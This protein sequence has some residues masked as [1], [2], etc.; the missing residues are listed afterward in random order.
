MPVCG[1]ADFVKRLRRET[2]AGCFDQGTL[3]E[4]ALEPTSRVIAKRPHMSKGKPGAL[5]FFEPPFL[6]RTV[7]IDEISIQ[8]KAPPQSQSRP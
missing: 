6:Q 7:F 4:I 3:I 1:S 8:Q 2:P 5:Q